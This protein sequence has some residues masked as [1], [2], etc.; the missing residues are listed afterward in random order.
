M[1]PWQFVVWL[2][3][4]CAAGPYSVLDSGLVLADSE[5]DALNKVRGWF[6]DW[7]PEKADAKVAV[8]PFDTCLI[9]RDLQ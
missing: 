9:A 2:E 7:G 5:E 4:G 6:Y 3:N 1:V 8:K